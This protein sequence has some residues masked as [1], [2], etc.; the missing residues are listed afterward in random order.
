M[1]LRVDTSIS[2]P[3]L[4]DPTS[5]IVIFLAELHRSVLFTLKPPL[6]LVVVEDNVVQTAEIAV[7][8]DESHAH[9]VTRGLAGPVHVPMRLA[10]LPTG[11]P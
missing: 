5:L 3:E 11:Q 8:V 1:M 6:M 9:P 4:I 10:F 7:T 2:V